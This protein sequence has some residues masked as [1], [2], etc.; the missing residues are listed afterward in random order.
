M[1]SAVYTLKICFHEKY[2]V[3]NLSTEERKLLEV[4]SEYLTVNST[5][6]TVL[7]KDDFFCQS[8]AVLDKWRYNLSYRNSSWALNS[9]QG[10]NVSEFKK[11]ESDELINPE[12]RNI[13]FIL[14][15]P[16]KDEFTENYAPLSPA[17]GKTGCNFQ[18]YFV[19]FV[20]PIL[21]NLGANFN[22]S[23]SY[24]ICFVNPV[25]YQTSLFQ[26]H[27]GKMLPSLR[28]K[29][30][31]AIYPQCSEDFSDRVKSYKPHMI[32]NSCTS[33]LKNELSKTLEALDI[34]I[35][36]TSHPAAWAIAFGAFRAQ[37]PV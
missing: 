10:S 5:K 25:P 16:H 18:T 27:K 32:I 28:D 31:K 2:H 3:L 7:L 4:S 35:F 30:W 36:E 17:A 19:G 8:K 34:P 14:E 26:A 23:K 13:L 29:V 37:T 15:S 20:L 1:N 21:K 22:K 12:M 24:S 6:N 9:P 33:Q 11:G